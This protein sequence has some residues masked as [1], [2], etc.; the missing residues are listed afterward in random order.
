MEDENNEQD[1]TECN[2]CDCDIPAKDV[3]VSWRDE[4]DAEG[5]SLNDM[6]ICKD[7][8]KFIMKKAKIPIQT[9][10]KVVEKIVEKPVER[11]IYKTIDKNG[12]EA[13]GTDY[14]TKFD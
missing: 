5:N 4:E 2:I 14:K 10:T 8:L 3:A 1:D 6:D 11:I 13:G 7:C 12:N 9:E